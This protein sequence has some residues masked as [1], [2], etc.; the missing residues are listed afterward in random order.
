MM[1]KNRNT[2][3]QNLTP[4]GAKWKLYSI[5]LLTFLLFSNSLFAFSEN[6]S[7]KITDSS[8]ASF[9]H[10]EEPAIYIQ[11]GTFIYGVEGISQKIGNSFSSHNK[12]LQKSL[13][14]KERIIAKV[15]KI[16][17]KVKAHQ[18]EHSA[19]IS[20][21]IYPHES[22]GSFDISKQQLVAGALTLINSFKAITAHHSGD[23][24]LVYLSHVVAAHKYAFSFTPNTYACS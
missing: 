5:F 21:H 17:P 22:K 18:Q 14:K 1:R 11:E 10:A 6:S 9:V 3:S 19:E 15:K 13:E 16:T 7:E 12:N 8:N 20:V 4:I 2:I 23:L 24:S